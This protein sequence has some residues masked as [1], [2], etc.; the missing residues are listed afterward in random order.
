MIDPDVARAMMTS[1]RSG[2]G[3][4]SPREFEVLELMA[5]GLS[6][7]QIAERLFLSGAAVAKHG[8]NIF[9]KLGLAPK[10]ENRRVRAILAF[11][12]GQSKTSSG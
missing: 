8:S 4:L 3:D 7:G 12:S 5:Q 2:L 10:E 6:N 9:L 1:N 11:L